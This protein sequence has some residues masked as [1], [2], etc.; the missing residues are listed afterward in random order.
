MG[1]AWSLQSTWDSSDIN[2]GKIFCSQKLGPSAQ[3]GTVGLTLLTS[4]DTL[5]IWWNI[6]GK[7]TNIQVVLKWRTRVSKDIQC[8]LQKWRFHNFVFLPCL[9][10]KIMV[11]SDF[12][13]SL[14]SYSLLGE[15]A[16]LLPYYFHNPGER[17][18]S[19][20]TS[21]FRFKLLFDVKL[22]AHKS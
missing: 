8:H 17:W 3:T 16:K 14:C 20:V 15:I 11:L 22:Q 10:I 12:W 13:L 7:T 18:H 19:T 6:S 5:S 2:F 21:N 4:Q 1:R 9:F